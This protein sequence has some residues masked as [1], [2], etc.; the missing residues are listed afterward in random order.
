M[1]QYAIAEMLS[2][3]LRSAA[4]A[5]DAVYVQTLRLLIH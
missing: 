1:L 3:S 2:R 5:V 4:A